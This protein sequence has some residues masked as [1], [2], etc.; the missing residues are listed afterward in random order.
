MADKGFLIEE[1]LAELRV[2]L[3]IPPFK[4]LL[5]FT[6]EETDQTQAI[7]RLRILIERVIRRVKETHLGQSS[8]T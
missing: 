5:R 1:M 6:K 8:A 2:K 7:A 3:I 4:R